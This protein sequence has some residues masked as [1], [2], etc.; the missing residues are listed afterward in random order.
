VIFYVYHTTLAF[1]QSRYFVFPICLHCNLLANVFR[2]LFVCL[3]VCLF[4]CLFGLFWVLLVLFVVVL[5]GWLVGNNVSLHQLGCRLTIVTQLAFY[6]CLGSGCCRDYCKSLLVCAATSA[7][8]QQHVRRTGSIVTPTTTATATAF[9]TT[10]GPLL[11]SQLAMRC[12]TT[13]KQQQP[14]HQQQ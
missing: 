3:C 10:I 4:I 8:K 9:V 13:L 11:T 7:A 1:R 2:C 5:V 12:Q 6:N 14:Q